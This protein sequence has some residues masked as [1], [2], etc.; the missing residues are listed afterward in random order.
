MTKIVIAPDKFKGSLKGIEFCNIVEN[1]LNEYHPN[2]DIIKL[3]LADGGDGTVEV[4]NY[5]LQGETNAINV[6]NPL[7]KQVSASYLYSNSQKTAYIEMA[8]A[9]GLKLL[10]TDKLNP[11]K[12][13]TYGTGE[14]ILDA[15]K[16]GAE[17]IILGIG[18]SA[19]NDCGIGMAKALGYRFWDSNG[20]ELYGT[21][22]DLNKLAHIDTSKS[23]P[24]LK[25]IKFEVACDVDNPLYGIN[26]AAQVYAPQKGAD[27]K[28]VN[29]LDS[30]LQNFNTIAKNQFKIDL[31]NIPGSGA[32]GG[33]GAGCI[34]FLNAELKSGIE[35]I[36]NIAHYSNQVQNADWI[37]TGEGKLD[38]QT[39]SGKV[40]SGII[41]SLTNQKLA[42]FC[43][44]NNFL[45]TDVSIQAAD[46]IG[47]LSSYAMNHS[48]AIKN[49]VKYL[50]MATIDFCNSQIVNK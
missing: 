27:A 48:D 39:L 41:H 6:S 17:H 38:N 49:V 31:Q 45:K 36:M 28:M 43:G 7:F 23:I 14:L 26:G 46:Y 4:I 16:T 44:I 8:E 1:V 30:G 22:E 18:G 2:I 50:K 37:I 35:L 20:H 12:T 32:A 11:L 5:Y 24:E 21:G 47:E 25:C 13:S 3:P 9:S 42:I 15:I 19:T 10:N 40:I 34:L 33:L 29:I